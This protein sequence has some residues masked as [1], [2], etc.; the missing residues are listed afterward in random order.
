LPG[1]SI[2]DTSIILGGSKSRIYSLINKGELEAMHVAGK[3][4]ITTAS[5]SRLIEKGKAGQWP[6]TVIALRKPSRRDPMWRASGRGP[7]RNAG[8][9]NDGRRCAAPN[10]RRG[11]NPHQMARPIIPRPPSPSELVLVKQLAR[12]HDTWPANVL[13]DLKQRRYNIVV[14]R[15]PSGQRA[16]AITKHDAERYRAERAAEGYAA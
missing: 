14:T 7:R 8:R 1:H 5:I 12:E 6:P 11:R 3:T 10:Q 13:R 4:L 16:S 9:R 15:A 2:N